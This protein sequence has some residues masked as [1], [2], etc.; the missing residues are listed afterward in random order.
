M[1]MEFP[2]IDFIKLFVNVRSLQ[3][4]LNGPLD[5]WQEQ[6]VEFESLVNRPTRNNIE[7]VK[8]I[9][10]TPVDWVI[11]RTQDH[12]P[13]LRRN[14]LALCRRSDLSLSHSTHNGCLAGNATGKGVDHLAL[15]PSFMDLNVT[16]PTIKRLL[17]ILVNCL[18]VV[19]L[20]T[21]FD[22]FISEQLG[23]SAQDGVD[24]LTSA[25]ES[26]AVLIEGTAGVLVRHRSHFQ[27]LATFHTS[28]QIKKGFLSKSFGFNYHVCASCGV[29]FYLPLDPCQ[30]TLTQARQNFIKSV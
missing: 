7:I 5:G 13:T 14:P 12:N 6:I 17:G 22:I 20:Q 21:C 29:M 3:D 28:P 10:I 23:E 8:V 18:L 4:T 24:E 30:L 11:C 26:N 1:V 2:K 19:E 16:S 27:F 9:A 15:V 25:G